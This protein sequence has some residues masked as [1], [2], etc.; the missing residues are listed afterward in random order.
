MNA[1][2]FSP[3]CMEFIALLNKHD[4][5]FVIVGGEAVIIMDMPD[6]PAM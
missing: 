3:D 4:V 2:H 6:L 1:S 5:R